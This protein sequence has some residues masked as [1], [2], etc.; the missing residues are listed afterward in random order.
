MNIKINHK[1]IGLVSLILITTFIL[2]GCGNSTENQI[3]TD[4][5]TKQEESSEAGETQE[6]ASVVKITGEEAQEIMASGDPYLLVDVR[7][8]EEYDTG[9]IEGAQLLPLDELETL[10]PDKL[11]DKEAVIL[12]YCRSGNRSGQAADLLLALGYTQVYDFGGI[13]DWPG[14]IVK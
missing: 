14:E 4:E 11:T 1:W 2:L 13:I 10:A 7:T 6:L 12:L 3:A 9:H 8:K 5:M